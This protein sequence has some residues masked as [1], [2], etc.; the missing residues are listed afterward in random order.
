MPPSDLSNKEHTP[1]L[2]CNLICG[3]QSNI[4]LQRN[5]AY[6]NKVEHH[7]HLICGDIEL[8]RNAAYGNKVEH[9]DH[10]VKSS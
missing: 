6:G 4:E 1:H 2:Y 9:H 7:D 10:E 3:E 5:A 8:Q